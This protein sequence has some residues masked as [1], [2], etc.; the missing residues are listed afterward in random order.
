M[1][2]KLKVFDCLCELEEFEI[3]GIEADWDDFGDKFDANEEN[4]EPYGCGDM[5]FLAKAPSWE[6]LKKYDISAEEYDGIC[7]KLEEKLSFGCCGWCV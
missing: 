2:L 5:T 4:A 7:K 3:N 1:T 6:I